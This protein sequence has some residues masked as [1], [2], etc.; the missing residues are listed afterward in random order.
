MAKSR[1]QASRS[2]REEL[3]RQRLAKAAKDR[4][5][6][7]GMFSGAGVIILAVVIILVVTLNSGGGAAP[8]VPRH[9]NSDQSGIT[10]N[11]DTAV[12]GAPI[13]E[14]F[15]DFQCPVCGQ[16]ENGLGDTIQKVIKDGSAK[17]VNRTMTFLDTDSTIKSKNAAA[18]NANSSNR[19]AVAAACA[20][21]IPGDF[22]YP[23]VQAIFANQPATE[24]DGY[25]DT[26]LR[27]TIPST[28][29]I[30]GAD[31][32]AFQQCYDQRQTQKF[33]D[34]VNS[35]ARAAG[36][37]STPTIRLNGTDITR[38]LD[39]TKPST[40]TDALAAVSVS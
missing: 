26:V 39:A 21:T 32:T 28:V 31:L 18:G 16:F 24:G 37:N 2:R 22:Y 6:K 9:G 36:V 25:S 30:T 17:V 8:L 14:I 1:S 12:G 4:K 13:L 40:L 15:S 7:I 35:Q 27:D 3:E 10:P 33:V 34:S 29:G 23:F 19:A 5:I 38:D 20:D 11:A